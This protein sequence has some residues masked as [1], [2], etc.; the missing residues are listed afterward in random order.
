MKTVCERQ[1]LAVTEGGCGQTYACCAVQ[2]VPRGGRPRA[3][4]LHWHTLVQGYTGL[5]TRAVH[6]NKT[7]IGAVYFASVQLISLLRLHCG[8]LP[9]PG[10]GAQC[11]APL[12]ALKSEAHSS[13]R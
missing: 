3:V 4:L 10:R 1:V 12:C 8:D 5:E 6:K 2:P 13:Y 11:H 7:E 9:T